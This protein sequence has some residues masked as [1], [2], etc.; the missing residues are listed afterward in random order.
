MAISEWE[1]EDGAQTSSLAAVDEPVASPAPGVPP[2]DRSYR[3]RFLAADLLALSA[4]G[5][6]LMR[7]GA[8]TRFCLLAPAAVL[9]AFRA[10][11]L[12]A[13]QVQPGALEQISR[14]TFAT[15]TGALVTAWLSGATS[16]EAL[17]YAVVAVVLLSMGRSAAYFHERRR[18]IA[19][20]RRVLLVGTG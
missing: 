10:T 1:M 7:A 17:A 4:V 18:A 20:P 19:R 14:I 11:A 6:L 12:Y 2:D 15:C 3:Y 5:A 9:W 16:R 8:P 13:F